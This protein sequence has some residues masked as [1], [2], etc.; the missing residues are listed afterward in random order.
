MLRVSKLLSL[1]VAA[2]LFFV[3]LASMCEGSGGGGGGGGG[4]GVVTV[5][6]ECLNRDGFE[7][8]TAESATFREAATDCAW[9]VARARY[10][11]CVGSVRWNT[12]TPRSGWDV[13]MTADKFGNGSAAC[14]DSDDRFRIL[15]R[16]Y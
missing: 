7:Y 4:F 3:P 16:D 10:G 15:A 5:R 9:K 2:L 1:P 6:A 13:Q 14:G 12:G 11:R 8:A